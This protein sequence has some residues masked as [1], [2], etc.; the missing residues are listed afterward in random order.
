[1]RNMK[2]AVFTVIN[3]SNAECVCVCVCVCVCGGGGGGGV[4]DHTMGCKMFILY[5][6]QVSIFYFTRA[7]VIY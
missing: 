6:R 7:L 3:S 4:C 5:N 2:V 1:M